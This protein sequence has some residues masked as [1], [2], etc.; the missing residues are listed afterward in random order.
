MQF[1]KNAS[2]NTSF[3]CQKNYLFLQISCL[4]SVETPT[5]AETWAS[6]NQ[7]RFYHKVKKDTKENPSDRSIGQASFFLIFFAEKKPSCSL[8]LRGKK[9]NLLK[10]KLKCFFVS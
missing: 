4:W 9:N 7:K 5:T 8:C 6:Q 2:K 10:A 3:K 1:K